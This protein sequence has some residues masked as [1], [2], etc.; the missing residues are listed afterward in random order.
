VAGR[1]CFAIQI[2]DH[3]AGRDSLGKFINQ[4]PAHAKFHLNDWLA[5]LATIQLIQIEKDA[6]YCGLD[7][8]LALS[9]TTTAT[10][11]T[12]IVSMVYFAERRFDVE[13]EE[14]VHCASS[15]LIGLAAAAC[16][17][18]LRRIG[19]LTLTG[20]L[21]LVM[22]GSRPYRVTYKGLIEG[23]WSSDP[24]TLWILG[25]EIDLQ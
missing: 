4:L 5:T 19:W 25:A 10:D 14:I 7:D 16:I 12:E 1:S 8:G 24:M 2:A 9:Q 15:L 18:R 17:E 6:T 23:V 13:V 21:A 3:R 22:Y 11:L 20:K